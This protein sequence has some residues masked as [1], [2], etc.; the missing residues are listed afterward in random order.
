MDSKLKKR[1][2]I[3]AASVVIMLLLFVIDIRR[4]SDSQ[5]P[6]TPTYSLTG[7]A[8]RVSSQT[9]IAEHTASA[10]P[11]TETAVPIEET[12]LPEALTATAEAR[13]IAT[14][15]AGLAKATLRA[16]PMSNIVR[17]LYED[18]AVSTLY[19]AYKSIDDTLFGFNKPGY[20]Q[21]WYSNYKAKYFVMRTNLLWDNA[22]EEVSYPTAGCGLVFGYQD[23]A[24]HYRVFLN[25]DGNIRLHRMLDGEFTIM[26]IDYYG[27][28][29]RPTGHANLILAVDQGWISV[30]VNNQLITREYD[31]NL[32]DGDLAYAIAS[33]SSYDFGT[34]CDFK[35]IEL[36]I[37]E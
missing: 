10:Q 23:N 7:T 31:E 5:L 33:G 2:L 1:L 24:N 12:L 4:S 37:I 18:G 8:T 35:D 14:A 11:G 6:A 25:L 21:M 9:N 32:T 28:L 17:G 36:W 13:I 27:E 15:E 16:R 26:A 29:G 34:S 20:Y 19:G 3:L 30:Y 22:G